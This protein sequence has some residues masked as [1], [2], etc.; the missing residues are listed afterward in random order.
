MLFPNGTPAWTLPFPRD[1]PLGSSSSGSLAGNG[2]I[3]LVHQH[4]LNRQSKGYTTD[5][6]L[7]WTRNDTFD[8]TIQTFIYYGCRSWGSNSEQGYIELIYKVDRS[9]IPIAGTSF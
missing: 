7:L 9:M 2:T 8:L 6:T 1:D 5:G 4:L 3:L